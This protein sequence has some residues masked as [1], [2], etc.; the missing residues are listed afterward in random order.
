M[1]E[2]KYI[3]VYHLLS[4]YSVMEMMEGLVRQTHTVTPT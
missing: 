1:L 3:I 4:A 2:D